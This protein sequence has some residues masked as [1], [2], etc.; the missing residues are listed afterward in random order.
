MPNIL[1]NDTLVPELLQEAATGS[2]LADALSVQLEDEAGR[3]RLEQRYA[4][5]HESLRRDTAG[6]AGAAICATIESVR[7]RGVH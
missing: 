4:A 7:R 2:A 5:M 1:A 3:Q 6:E